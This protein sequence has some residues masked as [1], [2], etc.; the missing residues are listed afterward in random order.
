MSFLL[1]YRW[2]IA[3]YSLVG[4]CAKGSLKNEVAEKIWSHAQRRLKEESTEEIRLAWMELCSTLLKTIQKVSETGSEQLMG[5]M[6]IAGV[7]AFADIQKQCAKLIIE[8]AQSQ[9]KSVDY[10][11]ERMIRLTT[12]LLTHKHT[13]VRV[14]G[15]K[16]GL[17]NK[18][19]EHLNRSNLF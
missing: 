1:I 3:F 8:Y 15:I 13:A 9:P 5:I 17:N 11:C 10:A 14:S 18:H 2:F 16:V 19:L 4:Q 7:D 6:Q 12:P